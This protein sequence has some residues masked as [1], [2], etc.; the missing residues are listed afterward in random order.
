MKVISPKPE[1][2]IPQANN[3]LHWVTLAMMLDFLVDEYGF[4]ELSYRIKINCFAINPTKKSSLNF[5]RK[6]PWAREK[7]E[8]L[9]METKAEHN[10]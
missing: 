4:E 1:D 6:T 10:Q 8:E 2:K 9:Y 7:V 3:P 5:L